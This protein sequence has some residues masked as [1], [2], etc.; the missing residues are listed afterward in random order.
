MG[1]QEPLSIMNF[2]ML[3]PIYAL[4]LFFFLRSLLQHFDV[5]GWRISFAERR[6]GLDAT[7]RIKPVF[8]LVRINPLSHV[9]VLGTRVDEL[10]GEIA[11]VC[12][13]VG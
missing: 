13:V 2:V 7:I 5:K 6:A 12:L 8:K 10:I 1:V 4:E 11:Y 3:F 9:F